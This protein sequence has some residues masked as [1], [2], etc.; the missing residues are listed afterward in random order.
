AICSENFD[1]VK[2]IPRLLE[3]GHTFC[4]VCIYSMSVDFKVICPNCKIVTL[5]P[6]GKTLPKNF[7]MISLTEQIM[8]LKIDPKITCKACHSKFSSEAVRMC[9]GEKC[10]M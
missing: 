8:K 2:I 10:G 5:L 6:T 4:E 9:I 3:C 1:S 7:A